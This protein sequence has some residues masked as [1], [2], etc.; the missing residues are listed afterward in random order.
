MLVRTAFW[1]GP[2]HVVDVSSSLAVALRGVTS[3]R[4]KPIVCG[5]DK[6]RVKRSPCLG[7][8][9]S[10]RILR[11]EDF[12]RILHSASGGLRFARGV[13]SA[14]AVLTDKVGVARIGL[15]VGKHNVP[16][17]VDRVLAK[18]II[19]ENVRVWLPQIRE[20]C[21]R[22]SFGIDVSLRV[23]EPV[24]GVGRTISLAMLKG[25]LRQSTQECVSVLLARIAKQIG[26][27]RP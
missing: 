21:L 1:F 25:K 20:E 10:A 26:R 9:R 6:A 12:G 7:F 11:S 4:S 8:P 19:R 3:L 23:R 14:S 22:G 2:A 15:T 13:V 16:R 27:G 5:Q 17:A 18:R 24:K